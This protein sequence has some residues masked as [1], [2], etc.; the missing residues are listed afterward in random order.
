MYL[1]PVVQCLT[2]SQHLLTWAGPSGLLLSTKCPLLLYIPENGNYL[3]KY[4]HTPVHQKVSVRVVWSWT[5]S[6]G[7]RELE[8]TRWATVSRS[9]T[10]TDYTLQ[11]HASAHTNLSSQSGS[12]P[13]KNTQSNSSTSTYRRP[14]HIDQSY[15]TDEWTDLWGGGANP[16]PF[17]IIPWGYNMWIIGNPVFWFA[18]SPILFAILILFF[19][20][21]FIFF[22]NTMTL[23][24][25]RWFS[26]HFFNPEMYEV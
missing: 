11:T 14:H 18:L 6:P 17:S 3:H 25:K 16:L 12:F 10:S 20:V 9:Q 19:I 23:T 7:I 8:L 24:S 21:L 4:T 2:L 5:D 15:H 1:I 13:P 26:S 22:L